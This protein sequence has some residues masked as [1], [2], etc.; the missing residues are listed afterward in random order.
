M[1]T[2]AILCTNIWFS[3]FHLKF[4][5]HN[6]TILLLF[7]KLAQKIVIPK[8]EALIVQLPFLFWITVFFLNKLLPLFLKNNKKSLVNYLPNS[9]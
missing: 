5:G 9:S 6:S 4:S 1:Y 2:P 3:I 7:Q 8:R